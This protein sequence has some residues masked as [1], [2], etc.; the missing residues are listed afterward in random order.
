MAVTEEELKAVAVAPRVT[1]EDVLASIEDEEFLYTKTL[2]F[3]VLTLKNGFTV[4]GESACASPANYNKEIGDRLAKENAINK[5]WSHL[6]FELRT[7]LTLIEKA[8]KPFGKITTLGK[9]ITYVGNSIVHALPMT[10]G[11]YNTLRGWTVPPDENADD[12]GYVI[13]EGRTQHLNWKPQ[14]VFEKIYDI[15]LRVRQ[16]PKNLIDSLVEERD[17][18][19]DRVAEVSN[20]IH[21]PSFDLLNP[22]QQADFHLQL[23]A[24]N[25]YL[26]VLESRVN[27][28]L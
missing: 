27:K 9:P 14:D 28:V 25:M 3:C 26:D 10:R 24:M 22:E 15:N 20:L 8:G 1:K 21:S 11:E 5:I 4:T 17:E 7:K 23:R 2:T 6:G 12:N 13:Q 19:R 18:I 16:E